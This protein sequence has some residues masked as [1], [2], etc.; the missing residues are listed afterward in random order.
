MYI[1]HVHDRM[2]GKL[3]YIYTWCELHAHTALLLMCP[4]CTMQDTHSVPLEVAAQN[5]HSETVEKLLEGGA[6]IDYQN[7]VRDTNMQGWH[8]D[9][10]TC[11]AL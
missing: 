9:S 5:G 6:H 10:R 3:M 2:N 1:V 4:T 7:K 11:P 8:H